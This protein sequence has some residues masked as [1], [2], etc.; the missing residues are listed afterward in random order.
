MAKRCPHGK[1]IKNFA[2]CA[3]CNMEISGLAVARLAKGEAR[4]SNT[5]T[6]AVRSIETDDAKWIKPLTLVANPKLI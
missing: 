5:N 6:F 4:L 1:R 2:S 3:V